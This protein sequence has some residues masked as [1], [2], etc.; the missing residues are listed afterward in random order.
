M[1]SIKITNARTHNLKNISLELP[2]NKLI[3][4]SG[5]SGSG[6]ASLVICN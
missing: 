6:N 4:F 1:S 2:H 5:I 3:V